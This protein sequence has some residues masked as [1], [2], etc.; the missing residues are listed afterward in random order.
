MGGAG[1]TAR[2]RALPGQTRSGERA[3]GTRKNSAN[4]HGRKTTTTSSPRPPRDG[5]EPARSCNHDFPIGPEKS[6]RRN[7]RNVN[8]GPFRAG[9]RTLEIE[10][11]RN[12]RRRVGK[13]Y[14]TPAFG[15]K[16]GAGLRKTRRVISRGKETVPDGTRALDARPNGAAAWI[17]AMVPRP[18]R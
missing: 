8:G 4:E 16:P 13:F 9:G 7:P 2:G 10:N 5:V 17:C 6:G 15:C 14:R 11:T 18:I 12:W 1:T 3:A